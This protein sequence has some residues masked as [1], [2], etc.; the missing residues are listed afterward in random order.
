[1]SAL[2]SLSSLLKQ[3][4]VWLGGVFVAAAGT[5][6]TTN[7]M[8][9]VQTFLSEKTAEKACQ[10]RQKPVAS[11]SQFT[12]LVSP[13]AHDPDKL[14]TRKIMQAFINEAGFRVVPICESLNFD[15]LTDTQSDR[16]DTL[17]RAKALINEQQADLL[18]F[19]DVSEPGKAVLIYAVN[20]HGGCDPKPKPME[21]KLGVLGSDF[22]AEEKEKLI[23]VSL[24]EI[25][26][27]CLNQSSIDWPLFA[28]R[29]NKMEM[30]L[31]YF[32]FNQANSLK[33]A[34]S[35]VEATRLLYSNSQGERWFRKGENFAKEITGEFRGNKENLSPIWTEYGTL[36]FFRFEKTGDKNDLATAFDAYDKAIGLDPK[37]AWAYSRRGVVYWGMGDFDR[38]IEDFDNAIDLDP[39]EAAGY[40]NRGNAY[41]AKGDS[42]RAITDY[43]KA[44][45]LDP[46]PDLYGDRGYAYGK[47]GDWD[48]T[49][50]DYTKA[51]ELDPKVAHAY[52]DR[53]YAYGKK[54]DWDRA[55]EDYTKAI[56]LDPK[57]AHAYGA[58]GYA[59]GKKGDW[60]RAIEDYTKAIELDPKVAA[61]YTAR[62]EAYGA[63]RDW[64]RAIADYDKAIELDPKSTIC[65]CAYKGRGAAYLAKDD[66]NRAIED[67]TKAIDFDPKDAAAYAERGL[68]YEKKGNWDRAIEDYS[69]AI[70]LDGKSAT[71]W[72]AR[73]M[74]RAIAG[75]LKQA[76]SDCNQSLDLEPNDANARDSRAFVYLKMD[77]LEG[78]I[79]DY[80]IALG[81]NPSFAASLYGRGVA[82]LKKGDNDSGNS[83]IESAKRIQPDIADEFQHYGIQLKQLSPR[84]PPHSQTSRTHQ[85][86]HQEAR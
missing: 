66:T 30:F 65:A 5:Y 31:R 72:N 69:Q 7:L 61:G 23:E 25:Q 8:T 81:L 55:I 33:F 19:G 59:Y 84:P 54:G 12:I 73:C 67:F 17:Q 2:A 44:I 35:Y 42:D 76:L 80:N 1:M 78:A 9:P 71:W 18:L 15:L 26:S 83:D 24:E 74:A 48:R 16:N 43:T 46:N 82:K 10:Y 53:G 64:D 20:E 85:S 21:I 27:A 50:E 22:T 11:D 4:A 41:L 49:I 77:K 70:R 60:D 28:K 52:G 45:G 34:S 56:E 62:G 6:V 75:H 57:V 14:H 36:Q 3:P 29:M 39:K 37:Y 79:A 32:D 58:R 47:K 51:I 68:A 38:A 86:R 40:K 13:L 63:K